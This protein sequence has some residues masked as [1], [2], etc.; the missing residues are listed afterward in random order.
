[1]NKSGVKLTSNIS[2]MT[3]PCHPWVASLK[4]GGVSFRNDRGRHK[5]TENHCCIDAA[6]NV[7]ICVILIHCIVLSYI[8][9]PSQGSLGIITYGILVWPSSY[10]FI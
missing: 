10:V 7:L 6:V 4:L 8:I 2:S 1:M 3:V 5:Q 9:L